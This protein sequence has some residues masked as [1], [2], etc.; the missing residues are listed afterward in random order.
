MPLRRLS[1]LPVLD[2]PQPVRAIATAARPI[3]VGGAGPAAPLPMRSALPAGV[4]DVTP[5]R[6]GGGA[7]GTYRGPMVNGLPAGVRDV[8]P[9]RWAGAGV[10]TQVVPQRSAL[11]AGVRDVTPGQALPAGVRDVTPG[12]ALPAG[13]RDVTRG[14][15]LPAGVRDVTPGAGGGPGLCARCAGCAGAS[16]GACACGGTCDGCSARSSG[17][18]GGCSSGVQSSSLARGPNGLPLRVRDVTPAGAGPGVRACGGKGDACG[19]K[20]TG[21][22]RDLGPWRY[23]DSTCPMLWR[24]EDEVRLSTSERSCIQSAMDAATRAAGSL[25]QACEPNAEELAA[26]HTRRWREA[27]EVALAA[28]GCGASGDQ[29]LVDALLETVCLEAPVNTWC[30]V[31]GVG[32][33]R[34][35]QYSATYCGN[36]LGVPH[37]LSVPRCRPPPPWLPWYLRPLSPL[38]PSGSRTPIRPRP[39]ASVPMPEPEPPWSVPMPEPNTPWSVPDFSPDPSVLACA[40]PECEGPGCERCCHFWAGEDYAAWCKATCC[41]GYR[42]S[43]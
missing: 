3:S 37:E 14:R 26:D 32:L 4:R 41:P 40:W 17:A 30:Y 22:R 8:T 1:H 39:L 31:E 27:F 20:R 24:T 15:A 11:P 6:L 35:V 19:A 21:K 2:A 34:H 12:W 36:T 25:P 42:E 28:Q 9:G 13:V 38:L 33:T 18:C 29:A 10:A 7:T 23:T 43:M 16:G 5:G